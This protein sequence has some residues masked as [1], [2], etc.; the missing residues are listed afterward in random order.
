MKRHK[1]DKGGGQIDNKY[2]HARELWKGGYHRQLAVDAGLENGWDKAKCPV[3]FGD[4]TGVSADDLLP[5]MRRVLDAAQEFAGTKEYYPYMACVQNQ[6]AT[7]I[8]S[9]DFARCAGGPVLAFRAG[10]E[11]GGAEHV[12]VVAD[13][14]RRGS[15]G[16]ELRRLAEAH[17]R[18]DREHR[19]RTDR[20]RQQ[21]R[22]CRVGCNLRFTGLTQNLGQ[23]YDSYRDFQ[24]KCWVNLHFLCQPC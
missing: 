1:G 10:E 9:R 22:R 12:G 15:R 19:G 3:L 11:H 24:S 13:E 23:L 6:V 17:H 5:I 8:C 14:E 18:G 2:G 20:Q 4:L 21:H 7:Q 16:V